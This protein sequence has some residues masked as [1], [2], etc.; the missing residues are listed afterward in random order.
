MTDKHRVFMARAIDQAERGGGG[1]GG[2]GS[3]A[4][5]GRGPAL[6]PDREG[7]RGAGGGREFGCGRERFR[8][9]ARGHGGR[10]AACQNG[11]H[12]E[13]RAAPP[14]MQVGAMFAMC[15]S[16]TEWAGIAEI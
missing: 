13:P 5:D 15:M 16:G 3:V 12:D 8:L 2:G 11:R 7:R 4:G 9:L 10:S 1:G 14:Y 6:E